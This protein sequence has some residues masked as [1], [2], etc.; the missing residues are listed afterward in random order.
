MLVFGK[1]AL[2][3]G[4]GGDRGE[5]SGGERVP[6]WGLTAG[7]TRR[8]LLPPLVVAK[9]LLGTLLASMGICG[10]AWVGLQRGLGVAVPAPSTEVLHEG[11]GIGCDESETVDDSEQLFRRAMSRTRCG[12]AR[13]AFRGSTG[14]PPYSSCVVCACMCVRVK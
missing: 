2:R 3:R 5:G 8:G 6:P 7:A 12:T 11:T 14:E 9:T 4:T 1:D 13:C 10:V